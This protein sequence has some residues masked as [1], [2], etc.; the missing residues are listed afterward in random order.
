QKPSEVDLEALERNEAEGLLA[1]LVMQRAR[2]QQQGELALELGV[3]K[4]AVAVENA[5]TGNLKLVAQLLGQ[6]VQHHEV[7]RTSI[8]ISADYLALRSAI[9]TALR[10]YPEAGRAVG[11]ALHALEVEAAQDIAEAKQPLVIEHRDAAQ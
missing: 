6:L 10:P 8:L 4:A 2:L 11:Q 3:V 5:I 7:R 1:Q 9:L